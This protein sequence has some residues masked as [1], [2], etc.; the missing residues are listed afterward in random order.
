MIY[1][2]NEKN[3]RH[4]IQISSAIVEKGRRYGH[5]VGHARR[6]ADDQLI[7]W[8]F[9]FFVGLSAIFGQRCLNFVGLSKRKADNTDFSW[10]FLF[11]VG[12]SFNF[13][14]RCLYFVG[15]S[16]DFLPTNILSAIVLFICRSGQQLFF[17]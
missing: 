15:L 4:E 11:F 10:A 17:S 13:G 7:S 2:R 3:A 1:R 5:F 16:F 12:L 9:L 6:K 14:Q 8:A